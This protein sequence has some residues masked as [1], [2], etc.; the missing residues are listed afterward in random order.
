MQVEIK[1]R[2]PFFLLVLCS[3]LVSCQCGAIRDLL[4]IRS[5]NGVEISAGF[6]GAKLP[7][8]LNDLQYHGTTTLS[9]KHKDSV[10]VCVDSK[11][12]MGDYVGSRTVRKVFPV[13]KSI[14]ATMAGGAADCAH[15][16]R[17]VSRVIKQAEYRYDTK[18]NTKSVARILSSMLK[19]EKGKGM[20][21]QIHL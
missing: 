8:P 21:S 12:S 18:L 7:M 16:I 20:K 13:S 3:W 15:W 9:F 2:M 19:D 17:L 6:S 11:A 4:H 14:V 5:N 1:L 10:I